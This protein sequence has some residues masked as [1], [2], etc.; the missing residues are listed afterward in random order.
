MLKL[1]ITVTRPKE[2]D[3]WTGQ[4]GRID[5]VMIRKY[6]PDLVERICYVCG[7]MAFVNAVKAA[8][9]GLG[10]KDEAVKAEMWGEKRRRLS[11][12]TSA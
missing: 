3:G 9:T 4:T 12:C 8:L 5:S 10:V 7:P 1:A 6:V 2:G 11:Y